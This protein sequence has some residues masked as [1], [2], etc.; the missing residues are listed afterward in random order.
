ML[1]WCFS[2]EAK[3]CAWLNTVHAQ[4][5]A[6]STVHTNKNTFTCSQGFIQRSGEKLPPKQIIKLPHRPPLIFM[7]SV[8]L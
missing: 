8:L 5:C 7:S 3:F 4:P 1:L 6:N 2:S